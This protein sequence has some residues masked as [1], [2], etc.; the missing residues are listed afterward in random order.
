MESG[1]S[2]ILVQKLRLQCRQEGLAGSSVMEGG[3]TVVNVLQRQQQLQLLQQLRQQQLQ[4][5]RYQRA[6]ECG[7]NAELNGSMA[8]NVLLLN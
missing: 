7:S 1:Y 3:S 5:Q 8:K 4:Q 2:L 6:R